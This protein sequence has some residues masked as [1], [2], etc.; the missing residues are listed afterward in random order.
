MMNPGLLW[1][2]NDP[3]ADLGY[4][5]QRAVDYT[6]RKYGW[7]PM[8]CF[9]HPGEANRQKKITGVEVRTNSHILPNHFWL[10]FDPQQ[11]RRK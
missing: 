10:E 6:Q 5:I 8:V 3:S 11:L 2:D 1:F 7:K 4:K 9:I